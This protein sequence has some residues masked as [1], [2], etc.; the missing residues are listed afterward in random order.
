MVLLAGCG[1]SR[2]YRP[3]LPLMPQAP[4][5]EAQTH[6]EGALPARGSAADPFEPVSSSRKDAVPD[7]VM[8]RDEGFNN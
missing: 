2:G 6:I 8:I 4:A 1:A 3:N 7:S 5:P